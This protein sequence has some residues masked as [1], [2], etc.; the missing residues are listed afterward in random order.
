MEGGVTQKACHYEGDVSFG[1]RHVARKA[2]GSSSSL[3]DSFFFAPGSSRT[4]SPPA[5]PGED[6]EKKQLR[7]QLEAKEETIREMER[8]LEK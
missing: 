1:G 2:I 3:I 8:E 5:A 4:V 7:L 6:E